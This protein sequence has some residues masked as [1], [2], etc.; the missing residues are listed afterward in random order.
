MLNKIKISWLIILLFL[1][2]QI[3][4]CFGV[5]ILHI[6]LPNNKQ[7]NELLNYAFQIVQKHCK[8]EQDNV[9]VIFDKNCPEQGLEITKN[10]TNKQIETAESAKTDKNSAV[11][12]LLEHGTYTIHI[13]GREV[14]SSYSSET[15]QPPLPSEKWGFSRELPTQLT[16]PQDLSVD[17]SPVVQPLVSS[18]NLFATQSSSFGL[19][20]DDGLST[21]LPLQ[22]PLSMTATAVESLVPATT[23]VS[24]KQPDI[25]V[26]EELLQYLELAP[27]KYPEATIGIMNAGGV[28]YRLIDDDKQPSPAKRAKTEHMAERSSPLSVSGLFQEEPLQSIPL[29]PLNFSSALELF[30]P[31]SDELGALSQRSLIEDLGGRQE[32]YLHGVP[33]GAPEAALPATTVK[34]RVGEKRTA[35]ADGTRGSGEAEPFAKRPSHKQVMHERQ[36]TYMVYTGLLTSNPDVSS[37]TATAFSQP[38]WH[39]N[40]RLPEEKKTRKKV[41]LYNG[42]KND[43]TRVHSIENEMIGELTIPEIENYVRRKN[44]I[45]FI[46]IYN[47]TY[48]RNHHTTWKTNQIEDRETFLKLNQESTS[49]EVEAQP[50]R[51]EIPVTL[52]GMLGSPPLIDPKLGL[53]QAQDLSAGQSPVVQPPVSF[54]KEYGSLTYSGSLLCGVASTPEQLGPQLGDEEPV[55]S[56]HAYLPGLFEYN[57][58][59][60]YPLGLSG[61]PPVESHNIEG[62]D[63]QDGAKKYMVFV[64]LLNEN[65]RSPYNRANRAYT[66]ASYELSNKRYP[67]KDLVILYRG[68]TTDTFTRAINHTMHSVTKKI[69]DLWT[70]KDIKKYVKQNPDIDP[71]HFYYHRNLWG[72]K[73]KIENRETFL[74]PNQKSTSN[75]VEGQPVRLH[76]TSEENPKI[77]TFDRTEIPAS[78]STQLTLSG[79]LGPPP[80]IASELRASGE[81]PT[82]P[83][84]LSAGQS[85]V[86]QPSVSFL[87]DGSLTCSESL[88]CGVA[89]ATPK[90][91]S[92]YAP[93]YD[94]HNQW[95]EQNQVEDLKTFLKRN[96]KS[97]STEVKA[98]PRRLYPP[99]NPET[100]TFDILKTPTSAL[101]GATADA[102]VQQLYQGKSKKTKPPAK[103]QRTDDKSSQSDQKD[104]V[105]NHFRP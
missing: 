27:E 84:D 100:P 93:S 37:K 52:S 78:A 18:T 67:N 66:R 16:F 104:F 71:I 55:V 83:Q 89:S 62:N 47:P 11:V 49:T 23:V 54:L 43:F 61:A 1:F 90:Q 92:D 63:Y 64:G 73:N 41:V 34:I 33:V 87:K 8:E 36:K 13:S 6:P 68:Y 56:D 65:L 3:S 48:K 77:P 76:P 103:K 10:P 5:S 51:T 70:R 57:Q 2:F 21:P 50:D 17:Q 42:Y 28:Y 69:A 20:P 88:L 31:L 94:P 38:M 58:R 19:K 39:L 99:S 22:P 82:L 85:P 53:P 86:V 7:P 45:I 102:N 4:N 29:Y 80:P 30:P 25:T 40:K 98:Q 35:P 59:L 95:G 75:E 101:P 26:S 96:Q 44:N 105:N 97:T 12:H 24:N 60:E 9:Y 72:K 15:L 74:N 91:A 32:D 14:N 46:Q 79:V 81:L